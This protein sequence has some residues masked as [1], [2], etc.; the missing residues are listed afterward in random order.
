MTLMEALAQKPLWAALLLGVLLPIIGR[1][2]VLGRTILLGLAVPQI[3][4]AGIAFLFLGHAL[5]WAWCQHFTDDSSLAATG[6]LLFTIPALLAL[7]GFRGA[8][9]TEA[10]LAFLYLASV[11]ATN[12]ML[13]SNAVGETY[14]SDLFH[15]RLLL[16]SDGSLMLLAGTLLGGFVIAGALRRRLLLVLTDPDF[17]AV[18]GVPVTR[19][20]AVLALLDGAV[21]GVAVAT[22]G[23]LVTFGFLILPA[24]TAVPFARS[25]RSH[26]VLAMAIGAVA[27]VAGFWLSYREDFPLGDSVVGA[28][29]ALLIAG[30]SA[31]GM[32]A[33]ARFLKRGKA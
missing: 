27:A 24:L 9:L 17:A 5:S 30:F 25:L 29:C 15:G 18:S 32:W 14:L 20:R 26:L 13:S 22:A 4:M 1:H 28:G 3:S 23:P 12:L 31:H 6:A 10:R 33:W 2:L 8:H 7:A 11:A 19:W 21:I 16:I